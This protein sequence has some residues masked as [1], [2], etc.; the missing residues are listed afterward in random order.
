MSTI[1]SAWAHNVYQNY[2]LPLRISKQGNMIGLGVGIYI[3]IAICTKNL[4]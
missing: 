2:S 1:I 3:Y 4:E